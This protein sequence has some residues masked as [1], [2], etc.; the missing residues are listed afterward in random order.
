MFC[1]LSWAF[2]TGGP[3]CCAPLALKI[4]TALSIGV[5]KIIYEHPPSLEEFIDNI[6][7]IKNGLVF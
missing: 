7:F 6:T 3:Q 5:D 2:Q 1:Q 4:F